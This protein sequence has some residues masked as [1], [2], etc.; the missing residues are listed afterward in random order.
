VRRITTYM[1]MHLE[2]NIDIIKEKIAGCEYVLIG[3][4][5]G[6]R[7]VINKI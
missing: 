5:S 4:G 7:T 3:A 2:N 6:L 1:K